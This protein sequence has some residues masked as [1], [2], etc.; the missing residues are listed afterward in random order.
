VSAFSRNVQELLSARERMA[1]RIE[2][3]MERK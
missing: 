2:T 1:K 3:L